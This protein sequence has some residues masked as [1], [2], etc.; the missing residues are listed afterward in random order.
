M[1]TAP[2]IRLKKGLWLLLSAVL[3]GAASGATESAAA[4]AALGLLALI[5][6]GF[7]PL[8]PLFLIWLTASAFTQPF[9]LNLPGDVLTLTAERSLFFLLVL[10]LTWRTLSSKTVRLK[11]LFED[12]LLFLFLL[13][14]LISILFVHPVDPPKQIIAF[15]LQLAIPVSFYWIAQQAIQTEAD[16]KKVY[17]TAS[18]VAIVL[19]VP[20]PIEFL[21]RITPLGEPAE[22]M[23]SVVRV[24]SF[25]RS[26]WELGA[27][28][29][30]LIFYGFH[31]WTSETSIKIKSVGLTSAALGVVGIFLTF[32]R[33][34]WLAFSVSAF[35]F[36]LLTKKMRKYLYFLLPLSIASFIVLLS[37]EVTTS[38]VWRDRIASSRNVEQRV[39]VS[40][41][42]VAEIR[43]EP[44]WGNGLMPTFRSYG[45]LLFFGYITRNIS[46]NSLLSLL[47][48]FGVFALMYYA[49]IVV[50]LLRVILYYRKFPPTSFLS[51]GL[52]LSLILAALAFLVNSLTFEIRLFTFVSSFFW[53]TL[54]LTKVAMRLNEERAV[55][56]AMERRGDKH[57][58]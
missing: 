43:Q 39:E 47:V 49:A 20:T 48:D 30:M 5:I 8:A 29:A 1:T 12:L 41:Q 10:N 25:L 6:F 26:P 32:M 31:I 55:E 46:H 57:A 28:L 21:F 19:C 9:A 40:R 14:A 51:R 44:V 3:L 37:S 4:F 11:F 18:I 50:I 58:E 15:A 33:G 34:A 2:G 52:A 35:I 38:D 23:D 16:L 42:Q 13:W 45:Y 7:F 36:L 17:L 56:Y 54:G 24:R 22:F 53:A 27:I